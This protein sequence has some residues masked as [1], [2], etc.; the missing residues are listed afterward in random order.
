MKNLTYIL[1]IIENNSE[2]LNRCFKSLSFE[3]GEFLYIVGPSNVIDKVDTSVCGENASVVLI[4]NNE[5]TDYITQINEGVKRCETAYFSIIQFDDIYSPTWFKH[6]ETHMKHF[7]DVS[8]F[9]PLIE[10]MSDKTKRVVALSNELSWSSSYVNEL[11]FID[12]DALSSFYDFNIYGGVFK[13]SDFIESGCLKPS[14]K[15]ASTYEL[16]LRYCELG[17]KIYVIPKI[18]YTHTIE[19]DDSYSTTISKNITRE[20]GEWLIKTAQEEKYFKQ[21]RNKTYSK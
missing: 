12:N 21:D 9:L 15:I 7:E 14:L 1:P 18:G 20:E 3:D 5:N 10:L 2:F 6:V 17:K 13:T 16:L 8:V 4:E 11:G 19:R